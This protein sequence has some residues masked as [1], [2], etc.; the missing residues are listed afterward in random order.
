MPKSTL[1]VNTGGT[2][3][4]SFLNSTHFCLFSVYDGCLHMLTAEALIH[5]ITQYFGF[6]LLL[7]YMIFSSQLNIVFR[8]E[9]DR[10]WRCFAHSQLPSCIPFPSPQKAL[11]S[12]IMAPRASVLEEGSQ[13]RRE[14]FASPE[15]QLSSV[16]AKGEEGNAGQVNF[17]LC[18]CSLFS[19][20]L[21][22]ECPSLR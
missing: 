5:I 16:K 14:N 15:I 7:L 13:G 9:L 21:Q 17:S 6:I 10:S 3:T 20:L 12:E 18:T 19:S 4:I 22:C 8:T 1:Q 2:F 11:G